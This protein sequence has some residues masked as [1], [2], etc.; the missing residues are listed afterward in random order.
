MIAFVLRRSCLTLYDTMDC[1]LPGSSVHEIL[2]ARILECIA[3]SSSKGSSQPREIK[4]IYPMSPALAGEFFTTSVIKNW[5]FP[6]F[7]K[8]D[9]CHLNVQPTIL[10]KIKSPCIL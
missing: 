3:I 4:L 9:N 1:N 10:L 7:S 5:I 6:G 8:L 2:L